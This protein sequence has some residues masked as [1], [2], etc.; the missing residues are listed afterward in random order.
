M[1]RWSFGDIRLVACWALIKY[2]RSSVDELWYSINIF[3][4]IVEVLVTMVAKFLL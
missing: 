3:V 2:F 4:V 1:A